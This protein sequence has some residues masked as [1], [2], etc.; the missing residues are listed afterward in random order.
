[1]TKFLVEK[2]KILDAEDVSWKEILQHAV[3]NALHGLTA[4][5]S[6]A[7][8]TLFVLNVEWKYAIMLFVMYV[9]Y[10]Q[11]DSKILNRNK[12]VTKLGKN[13]IFPFPSAF[14]FVS[15][16]FLSTLI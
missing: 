2:R 8:I 10:K 14:G 12:Y 6:M 1:M 11:F 15:G 7:F 16:V 3:V 13:Y 9:T 4:G 5:I